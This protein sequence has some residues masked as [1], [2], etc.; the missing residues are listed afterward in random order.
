[1]AL[2]A[3]KRG[4]ILIRYLFRAAHFLPGILFPIALLSGTISTNG[5]MIFEGIDLFDLLSG[6]VRK[7]KKQEKYDGQP[8]LLYA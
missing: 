8:K 4:Y 5:R 7:R 1:V 6:R 3:S 2:L